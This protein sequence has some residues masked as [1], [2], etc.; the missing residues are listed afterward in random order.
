MSKTFES[1]RSVLSKPK[2][3]FIIYGLLG[4]LSAVHLIISTQVSPKIGWPTHYNNYLIFKTSFWHL[5]DY[6]DLYLEHLIDHI[7]Y[8]KYSPS[9]AAL[10]M[11]FAYVPDWIGL[12][13][14]NILNSLVLASALMHLPYTENRIKAS[15]LAFA[16]IETL[17]SLQNA[18]S[19]ALIA[20]LIIWTFICLERKQIVWAALLVAL[21]IFIKIFG[22]IGFIMFLFYPN[23]WK[24]AAWSILWM[25]LIGILPLAFI[26]AQQL[27]YLY[28]SW[29]NLL[30][31]D[32]NASVGLSVQGWLISWFGIDAPK[33]LVLGIGAILLL[34]PLLKFKQWKFPIFRILYLSAILIWMVIFNHKA[35]SPTFVIAFSGVLIWAFSQ[36][37]NLF[38][39][40]LFIVCFVLC[41]LSQT[42]L[43][44]FYLKQHFVIPYVLKAVPVIAI[45]ALIIHQLLMMKNETIVNG[46]KK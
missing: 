25:I 9:F 10:M 33:N 11:P 45:F 18:Q 31:W 17:T 7:D 5:V 14:W 26:S 34:L 32:V 40:T 37:L 15:M 13:C 19:N 12:S 23:K 3:W 6:K 20:G 24:A 22:I 38:H 1:I 4:L 44:P 2:S 42:D 16:L 36:K 8:F 35:E 41:S 29:W 43:F 27:V 28:K 21:S 39:K 46:I 30:S